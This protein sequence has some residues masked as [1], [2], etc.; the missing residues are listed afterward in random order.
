[1]TTQTV[2]DDI[3]R[4]LNREF[5]A[6]H[7]VDAARVLDHADSRAEVEQLL[8]K[9]SPAAAARLVLA[10]D[11]DLAGDL[12]DKMDAGEFRRIFGR[13]ESHD[14]A[15]I[16]SRLAKGRRAERLASLSPGAAREIN[17]L[18][19]YPE[20]TAGSLMQP[21]VISFHPRDTVNEVL[22]RVRSR[23]KKH[24]IDICI[25]DEERRLIGVVS[26][27]DVATGAKGATMRDLIGNEA[28]SVPDLAPRED[29]IRIFETGRMAV[30]PVVDAQGRLVGMIRYDTLVVAAR[31]DASEDLLKMFGAGRE[32]RALSPVLFAVRKRLPW[33]EVN[34]A[35][36]FLAAAVVGVF[37][38][39]IAQITAL[40]VFLPVVAGQSG[41][42]G[43]QALAVT[44]R[45]LF[46][47]EIKGS[48]WFRMARKEMAVAFVN[49]VVVALTTSVIAY[50]WMGSAGLAAIIGVAMVFS[51]VVAGF[52]GAVIP[53]VLKALGQDPAQSSSIILTTVTDI[54]GF[55]SFLGLAKLLI[56]QI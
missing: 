30:L 9:Q 7:P 1:M 44:M 50:V 31:E 51:M 34:L 37:E 56:D 42:T 4:A 32:E 48:N 11:S 29:V 55:L 53:S 12:A 27:Q 20:N 35:T 43:S 2:T 5:L 46:L 45:G 26:L 24:V 52:F 8:A 39:T 3:L 28:I 54:A 25:V 19:T 16:L 15:E 22:T 14:C 49:G 10:L 41:N 21:A 36:A 23:R 17:D 6:G 13:L 18:L 33:L 40:A 47:R 38:S